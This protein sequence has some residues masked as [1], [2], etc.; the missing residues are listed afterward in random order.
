MS[1]RVSVIIPTYNNAANIYQ[2]VESAL[3]QTYLD[4]EVIVVDNGSKDNTGQILAAYATQIHY[5]LQENQERSA[6][7]NTLRV[8]I[9]HFGCRRYLVTNKTGTTDG[10][11]RPLSRTRSGD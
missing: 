4:R 3:G 9:S 6:A 8:T 10:P 11:F 2:A 7:R 1:A 5:I